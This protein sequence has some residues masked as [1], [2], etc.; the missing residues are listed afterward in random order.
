MREIALFVEDLAHQL[1]IGGLVERL[2]ADHGIPA[3]LNWL[4]AEGGHGQVT[5]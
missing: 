4:S 2:T 5:R 3:R 1:V